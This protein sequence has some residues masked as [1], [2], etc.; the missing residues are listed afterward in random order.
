MLKRILEPEVMDNEQEAID[1]D[2]MDF[3][4]INTAFAQLAIQLTSEKAKVL[5]VGT[6]TA[7]IPIV[8]AEL[9]P[10]W[11]IIAT[12]LAKSMLEVGTKNIK[13]S[14][15]KSQI[16]LE[17]IDAKKMPYATSEFDLV[18]ANSLVHH[19]PDPLPFFQETQRVLKPEGGILIRDLLRPD[20]EAEIEQIVQQTDLDYNPHQQKLFRDSLH[21]A[22]TLEEIKQIVNQVG[23]ENV[24]V[25]Q[26]SDIHWT[27]VRK[28]N[29]M[30][31]AKL[32][33]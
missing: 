5:D 26:S 3:A 30:P 23:I 1:Y 20:T 7:R 12:D 32:K 10:Q 28:A 6:G 9:R 21:A 19:L 14:G 17:F 11:Q 31:G 27:I 22:F 13:K 18:M 4:E 16:K 15:K 25:Y 2:T 24:K 8:I 33:L 29:L